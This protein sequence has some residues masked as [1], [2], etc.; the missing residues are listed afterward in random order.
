MNNLLNIQEAASST[1]FCKYALQVG[2]S[3]EDRICQ[4]RF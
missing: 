4:D 1:Y 3:E 2:T